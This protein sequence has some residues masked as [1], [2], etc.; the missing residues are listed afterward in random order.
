MNSKL[1]ADIERQLR[2]WQFDRIAFMPELCGKLGISL[3]PGSDGRLLYWP[4]SAEQDHHELLLEVQA[5]KHQILQR[6]DTINRLQRSE[7]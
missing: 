5:H 6:L 2:E 3:Q 7:P 1:R 4:R